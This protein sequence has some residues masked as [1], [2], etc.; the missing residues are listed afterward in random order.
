V[1]YTPGL[2]IGTWVGAF[3]N[4]IHFRSANGTGGQ[5]ALPIAGKVLA[6]I[7]RAP[8]L[9]KRYLLPFSWPTDHVPELDCEPR[10][11]ADLLDRLI[12]QAFGKRDTVRSVDEHDPERR[13][14]LDR[15]FKKR[16]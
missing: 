13:N 11:E 7:E 1:A 15:I 4:E 2:V 6:R 14:I 9:R 8:D 3:N 10:R 16:D 12:Q 5:L